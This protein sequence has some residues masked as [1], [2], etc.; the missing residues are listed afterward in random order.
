MYMPSFVLVINA[1]K[2]DMLRPCDSSNRSFVCMYLYSYKVNKYCMLLDKI[3]YR[4]V[5]VYARLDV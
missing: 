4:Y 1:Y 3:A 5:Q 2:Y